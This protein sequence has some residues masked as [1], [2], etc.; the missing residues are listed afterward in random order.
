M[1]SDKI[2]T[3]MVNLATTL[4]TLKPGATKAF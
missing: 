1:F 2:S 3:G 4:S